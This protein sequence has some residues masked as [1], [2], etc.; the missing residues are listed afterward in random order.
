ME[1]STIES[2]SYPLDVPVNDTAMSVGIEAST[3]L[4]EFLTISDRYAEA[5]LV[6]KSLA[7]WFIQRH[8]MQVS[9]MRRFEDPPTSFQFRINELDK[10]LGIEVISVT[11]ELRNHVG[12]LMQT[13][14]EIPDRAPT[15]GIVLPGKADAFAVPTRGTTQVFTGL[16][17]PMHLWCTSLDKPT[18]D[19]RYRVR[20]I[21]DKSIPVATGARCVVF[22][23]DKFN[24]TDLVPIPD[25]P[26]VEIPGYVWGCRFMV[27]SHG[28]VRVQK[29]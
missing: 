20:K 11:F 2:H 19:D 13:E 29:I 27:Q 3:R 6:R 4:R 12:E 9:G 10:V 24:A 7:P 5:E 18:L 14:G 8:A 26:S 28:T 21:Q 17:D 1:V 15:I 23:R 16:T 25:Q 22:D